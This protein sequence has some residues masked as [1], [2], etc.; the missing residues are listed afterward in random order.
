MTY[1]YETCEPNGPYTNDVPPNRLLL[2]VDAPVVL[3][4]L[5]D[6]P[7]VRQL[8]WV[9][10]IWICS[11][12]WLMSVKDFLKCGI[13]YPHLGS[14]DLATADGKKDEAN[15]FISL[16]EISSSVG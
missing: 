8:C 6:E 12:V 4:Q 16:F 15:G 10:D 14:H 9:F 1:T 5:V 3:K 2:S 11:L 13:S 7:L